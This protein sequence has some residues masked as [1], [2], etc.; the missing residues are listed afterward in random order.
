M[1]HYELLL[2]IYAICIFHYAGVLSSN[3]CT[4]FKHDKGLLQYNHLVGGTGYNQEELLF[5]EKSG[6]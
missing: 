4:I 1:D 2:F 5:D 3:F 6:V